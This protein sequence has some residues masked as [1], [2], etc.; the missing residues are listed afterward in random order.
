MHCEIKGVSLFT[1]WTCPAVP[2][3][4]SIEKPPGNSK[5]SHKHPTRSSTGKAPGRNPSSATPVKNLQQLGLRN[6]I[7]LSQMRPHILCHCSTKKSPGLSHSPP[8]SRKICITVWSGYQSH[9]HIGEVRSLSERKNQRD[10]SF[11]PS[12]HCLHPN[13]DGLH[14]N[15]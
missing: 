5:Q 15:Y 8:G 12:S 14:P 2:A 11:Y 10:N 9:A 3:E 6:C 13:S 7:C 1:V 4:S